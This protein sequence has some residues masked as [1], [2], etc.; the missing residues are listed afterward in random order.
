MSSHKQKKSNR[1]IER[2]ERKIQVEKQIIDILSK[3]KEPPTIAQMV[4]K[5]GL[6]R[7]NFNHFLKDL[8]KRKYIIKKRELKDVQGRPTLL[9][10]NK[11]EIKRREQQSYR[12][13]ETY[14][15]FNLREI[16]T[17]RLLDVIEKNPDS[18]EQFQELIKLFKE[19]RGYGAKLIF[20][21]YGELVEVN[22]SLTLTDKVKHE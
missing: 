14:E 9:I 16:L 6:S 19:D 5:S 22:Y 18:H 21:L 20:L 12:A 4:E 8:L 17:T 11:K 2:M 15:E 13:Y 3:E 7:G 1:L 10:L